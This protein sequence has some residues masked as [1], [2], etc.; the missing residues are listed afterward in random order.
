MQQHFDKYLN[1]RQLIIDRKPKLVVECGAG[2]G[3]NTA[4]LMRLQKEIPFK[5]IV[6][7]DGDINWRKDFENLGNQ[8]IVGI[9]YL[10]LQ[11]LTGIDFCLIDTDHNYPTLKWELQAL[12]WAMQKGGVVCIHDTVTY[13]KN[14]G[15]QP[16]YLACK[17]AYPHKEIEE[18]DKLGLGMKDAIDEAL[19]NDWRWLAF[20][21]ESHGAVA[22]IK[23]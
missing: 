9:S 15:R 12:E 13:A 14:N 10:E 8:W 11:K 19:Q 5:I 22:L 3:E 4:N 2:T 1:V 16:S 7:N 23:T 6:I 17:V 21:E 18:A 20:T